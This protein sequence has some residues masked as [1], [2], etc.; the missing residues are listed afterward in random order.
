MG[1]CFLG[2]AGGGLGL[3]GVGAGGETGGRLPALPGFPEA[4]IKGDFSL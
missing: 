4:S 1:Y 3:G 2:G